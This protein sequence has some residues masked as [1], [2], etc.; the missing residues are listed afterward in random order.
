M[1]RGRRQG[2]IQQGVSRRG[3]TLAE[4]IVI[5]FVLALIAGYVLPHV[6][7]YLDER[8]EMTLEGQIARLPAQVK[9]DAV[10]LQQPV[11]LTIQGNAL[12]IE[13]T[14]PQEWQTVNSSQQTQVTQGITV[15]QQLDLGSNIQI[16]SVQTQGQ[17]A[18]LGTW[19]WTVYPDGSAEDEGLEFTIGR[20]TRSLVLQSDGDSRW[21]GTALPDQSPTQWSAGQLEETQQTATAP[22]ATTP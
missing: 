7:S 21:L 13:E 1:T 11:A 2:F 3:F 8:D 4:M 10:R 17:P 6:A 9:N 14:P 19:T 12:V 22:S 20:Q 18:D 5:I 16:T 15:L